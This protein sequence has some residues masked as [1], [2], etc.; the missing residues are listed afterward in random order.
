M[1]HMCNQIAYT[2]I[3]IQQILL[4]RS[5]AG[6]HEAFFCYDRFQP[7]GGVP[8]VCPDGEVIEIEIR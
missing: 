6:C 2:Q 5:T 3:P 8:K 7:D 4:N 1:K